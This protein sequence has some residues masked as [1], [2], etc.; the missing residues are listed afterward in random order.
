MLIWF[1]V[2]VIHVYFKS[3]AFFWNEH[4]FFFRGDNKREAKGLQREGR[5]ADRVQTMLPTPNRL[6]W[7]ESPSVS[8]G[9]LRPHALYSSWNSPGQNTE[10]G[11]LSLCQGI[12]PTQGSNPRL[13]RCRQI[14]YQLSHKGSPLIGYLLTKAYKTRPSLTPGSTC[15]IFYVNTEF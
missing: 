15:F 6:K 3:R 9:S 8:S 1:W 5:A 12:F 10:V 13:P 11:G 7:S 4:F 14:L 2:I